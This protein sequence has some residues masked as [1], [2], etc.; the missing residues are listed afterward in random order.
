[1]DPFSSWDWVPSPDPPTSPPVVKPPPGS[2]FMS[3]TGPSSSYF[4]TERG[5]H[6]PSLQLNVMEFLKKIPVSKQEDY[7]E[8]KDNRVFKR[9]TRERLRRERLSQGYA[10]L[11]SMLPGL[12]I[13]KVTKNSIVDSVIEYLRDM[14]ANVEGLMR[15]NKE[16]KEKIG[17]DEE[18][19][20]MK[21]KISVGETSTAIDSVIETL[22][23]LKEMDVKAH[24]IISEF[25]KEEGYVV[26][27]VDDSK[28]A[29]ADA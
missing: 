26:V 4:P 3:Y 18:K 23:C 21:F 2:S 27:G 17:K 28:A 22:R 29:V 5:Q 10:D 24:S 20:E 13:K 19:G 6:K 11:Y 7:K 8:Q 1:M 14:E 12:I 16:L 15:H 9:M 25:S